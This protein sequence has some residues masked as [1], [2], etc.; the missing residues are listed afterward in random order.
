VSQSGSFAL[1]TDERATRGRD[2]I[3]EDTMTIYFI[4]YAVIAASVS[5]GTFTYVERRRNAD[6]PPM[7]TVAVL[8]V[9]LGALWPALPLGVAQTTLIAWLAASLRRRDEVAS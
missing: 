8:S 2:R 9:A 3:E 1:L 6:S 4:A 7:L 5:V